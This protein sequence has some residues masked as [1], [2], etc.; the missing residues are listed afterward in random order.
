MLAV[1]EILDIA[2]SVCIEHVVAYL[3]VCEVLGLHNG[4]AGAEEHGSA[5]HVVGIA[6]ADDVVVGDV[7]PDDR[8]VYGSRGGSLERNNVVLYLGHNGTYARR[9]Y[10]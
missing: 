5:Y 10:S 3:P 6:D 2:V 7:S 8:V 1:G 4:S 9:G